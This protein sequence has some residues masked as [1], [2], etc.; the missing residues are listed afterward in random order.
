M[1]LKLSSLED[2]K[3]L[4]TG[5]LSRN[6]LAKIKRG[7]P[8]RPVCLYRFKAA[9]T[10][11]GLEDRAPELFKTALGGAADPGPSRVIDDDD[12]EAPA[13]VS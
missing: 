6:T 13:I 9:L 7:A 4:A 2:A 3:V 5:A 1:A 10:A 8:V 12:D 11:L